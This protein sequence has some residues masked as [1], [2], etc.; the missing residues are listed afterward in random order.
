MSRD[1]QIEIQLSVRIDREGV[2]D[3]ARALFE[4]VP[5]QRV[6]PSPPEADHL[7]TTE[8]AAELLGISKSSLY[9]LRYSGNAPP[10]VKVGSRL[11]W[12][13]SDIG[14]RVEAQLETEQPPRW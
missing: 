7:L 4:L 9:T 12:R 8:E 11:R 10:A 5:Q 14:A 6:A 1:N 2:A 13:R 3:L